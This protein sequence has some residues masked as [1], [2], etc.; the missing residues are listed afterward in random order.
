[1]NCTIV[2]TARSMMYYKRVAKQWWAEA[3]NTA[4]YLIN[5]TT[6][7]NHEA[8]TPLN[9]ALRRSRRFLIFVYLVHLDTPILMTQMHEI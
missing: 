2:E 4:V 6:C 8:E 3:V 1:M 5:R 9:C 7:I